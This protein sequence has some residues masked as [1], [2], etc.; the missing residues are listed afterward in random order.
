MKKTLRELLLIAIALVPI[1]YLGAVYEGISETVPTH[2]NME[3]AVDGWSSKSSL[4]LLPGCLALF[5]YVVLAVAPVLDP[6]RKLGEMGGK[7]HGFRFMMV[8]FFSL[9]SGYMIYVSAAPGR[10]S[11]HMLAGLIGM[12]FIGLG[13]YMQTLRPNYFIGLR[14]PW[15]L[16]SEEVW[17]RTHKLAG[18]LA[19]AGG[20]AM[21]ALAIAAPT[22]EVL[23]YGMITVVAVAVLIPA[24]NSYFLFQRLK[25]V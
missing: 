9:L 12:L 21:L 14:T 2:F 24:A 10:F 15:T 16:E 13:N 25:K 22:F 19:I 5:I 8:I 17:R 18:R 7:Y 6:K 4:W 1:A 3:G 11:P 23:Y 20:I